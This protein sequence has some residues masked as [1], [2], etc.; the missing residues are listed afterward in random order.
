MDYGRKIQQK[1]YSLKNNEKSSEKLIVERTWCF[2]FEKK[3]REKI[4]IQIME[5][6]FSI[7]SC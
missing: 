4:E 6:I 5:A 7:F 3:M 2:C 1:L